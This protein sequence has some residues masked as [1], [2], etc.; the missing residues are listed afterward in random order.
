MLL[1]LIKTDEK[2]NLPTFEP[3]YLQAAK[4][5]EDGT[6]TVIRLSEQDGRRGTIKLPMKVKLLNMLE[7]TES[8]SDMIEYSPFEII[9]VG[10]EK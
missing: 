10:I 1:P 8:E 4:T 5:S 6:M 2:W 7:E 9:T 3:L